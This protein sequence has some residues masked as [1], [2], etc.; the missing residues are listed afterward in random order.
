MRV[1]NTVTVSGYIEISC[2]SANA[3]SQIDLTIPIASAFTNTVQLSGTTLEAVTG[4][5]SPGHGTISSQATDD[6][7]TIDFTPRATG[8]LSYRFT[9]TYQIL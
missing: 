1:G 6:R 7:L 3:A 4:V 2:T 9:Y 5:A 8:S